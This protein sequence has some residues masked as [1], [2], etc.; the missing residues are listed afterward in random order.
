MRVREVTSFI[1]TSPHPCP[2]PYGGG[3][4]RMYDQCMSRIILASASPQRKTLLAGLGVNFDVMPSR[5]DESDCGERD[6]A[7][8]SELLSALKA[9][10]VASRH[11]GCVIIGC[12]T[13]VVAPDGQL[14]EK[15]RDEEDAL[16]MLS[17]QSG[18]TSL[19]HSAVTV[20]NAAGEECSGISTSSVMFKKL[21]QQEEEWWISTRLWE[22]RSGGFQIDGPGQLMIEKIEG[23]WSGVVGLP[24]YLLG[25]LLKKA[26]V[27]M[28]KS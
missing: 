12:D 23:D 13:L 1:L 4:I 25:E 19:V 26:G 2:S 20:I 11:P 10:D 27:P 18:R 15:P 24:V 17:S 22:D 6:P 3:G 14:L 8:R 7:R 5:V 16:R 28:W 9:R 21:S